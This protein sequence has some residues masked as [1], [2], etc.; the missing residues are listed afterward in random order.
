MDLQKQNKTHDGALQQEH[1]EL[2]RVRAE[3]KE[4]KV[5]ALPFL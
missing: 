2:S 5:R 3:L 1:C 4:A